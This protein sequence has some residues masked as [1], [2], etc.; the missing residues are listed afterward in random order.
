MA[1][2]PLSTSSSSLINSYTS[3]PFSSVV[4][5]SHFFPP[6]SSHSRRFSR[7]FVS[8]TGISDVPQQRFIVD[9]SSLVLYEAVSENELWAAANLRI[10]TF[11]EFKEDSFGVEVSN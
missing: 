9:K 8:S 5:P 2:F 1:T 4:S 6:F 10:R 7:L 11:N 3:S